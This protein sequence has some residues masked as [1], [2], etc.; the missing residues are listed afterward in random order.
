MNHFVFENYHT[1]A[2]KTYRIFE[3]YHRHA[4]D[5][6][7]DCELSLRDIQMLNFI[8]KTKQDVTANLVASMFRIANNALSNRLAYFE[9]KDIVKRERGK[10]DS[11]QTIISL[12]RYGLDLV[13]RYDQYIQAYIQRVRQT[14]GFTQL[15]SVRQMLKK[16]NKVILETSNLF[17]AELDLSNKDYLNANLL[18]YL[19]YYFSSFDFTLSQMSGLNI[20]AQD[21]NIL[22]ELYLYFMNGQSTITTFAEQMHLHYQSIISKINKYVRN[23][24]IIE[25]GETKYRFCDE[26]IHYLEQFLQQRVIVYYHTMMQ[27]NDKEQATTLKMFEVLKE[28]ASAII[29]SN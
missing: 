12:E 9:Q 15:N 5:I 11:R 7:M 21:T 25:D 27:F 10:T 24:L 4:V 6:F 19:N 16:F 1:I 28:H 8:H 14:F 22:L 3:I 13:R 18:F 29:Q 23:G 17:P 2:N 20:N 26:L